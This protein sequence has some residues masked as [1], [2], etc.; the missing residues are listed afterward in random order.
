MS[1]DV[2]PRDG[3]RTT[4]TL[5]TNVLV[6]AVD[7]AAGPRRETAQQTI[8]L[9]LQHGGCRL[10]LQA[11]SEFYAAATRKGMM[12]SADAAAQGSDWLDLFPAPLSASAGAVRVALAAAAARRLSY[13]DALLVATAAEGGCAAV[14][15]EDM[16]DGAVIEGIRVVNPF[17]PGGRLSPT[18][19]LLLGVRG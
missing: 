11:I 14:L 9:A 19:E 2:P 12:P 16:A 7:T 15:S 18:V 10:T 3:A 5:D 1:A 13:W 8:E 4:F 17:G 6:Y